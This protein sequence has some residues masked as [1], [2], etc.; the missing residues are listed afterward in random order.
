MMACKECLDSNDCTSTSNPFCDEFSFNCRGCESD[1]ECLSKYP[2]TPY[3]NTNSRVCVGCLSN[4][5]WND[6]VLKFCKSSICSGCTDNS[7]CSSI[8]MCDTQTGVCYIPECASSPT[9]CL[10]PS[11][12]FCNSLY[13]CD[14]CKMIRT[15]PTL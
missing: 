4:N 8:E 15:V 6:P 1:S 2:S 10:T 9:Q 13:M 7:D 14:P 3:C 11:K 12:S 5:H